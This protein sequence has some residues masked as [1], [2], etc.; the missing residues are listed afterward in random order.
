MKSNEFVF[1]YDKKKKENSIIKKGNKSFY[2]AVT[3][4]LNHKKIRKK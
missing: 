3:V 1:H 2:H 4:V